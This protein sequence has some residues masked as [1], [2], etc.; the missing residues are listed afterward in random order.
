MATAPKLEILAKGTR[1]QRKNKVTSF[2]HAVIIYKF[3]GNLWNKINTVHAPFSL[4]I[5][6][7]ILVKHSE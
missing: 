2:L 5:A 7:K 4:E 6:A 1:N 3:S